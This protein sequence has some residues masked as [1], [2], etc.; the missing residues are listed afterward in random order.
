MQDS[1]KICALES[2]SLANIMCGFAYII[3]CQ[4]LD[5]SKCHSSLWKRVEERNEGVHRHSETALLK[6]VEGEIMTC[7]VS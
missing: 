6:G 5:M 1:R 4:M 2:E 7:W 3:L